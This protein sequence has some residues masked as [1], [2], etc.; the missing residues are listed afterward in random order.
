MTN[1]SREPAADLTALAQNTAARQVLDELVRA[2][3]ARR[4]TPP[5]PRLRELAREAAN[6]R[7]RDA[8]ETGVAMGHSGSTASCSYVDCVLVRTPPAGE[9]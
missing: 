5:D 8:L 9:E 3:S 1:K 7:H 2:V 6:K 4:D